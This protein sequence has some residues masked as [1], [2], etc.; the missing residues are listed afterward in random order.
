[1][2][3]DSVEDQHMGLVINR[4]QLF[5]ENDGEIKELGEIESY[6]EF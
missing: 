3:K 1:M 5:L 4:C 2:I 6:F